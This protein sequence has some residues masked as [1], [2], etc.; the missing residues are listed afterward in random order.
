MIEIC[1][2]IALRGIQIEVKFNRMLMDVERN[3]TFHFIHFVCIFI[4]FS[5]KMASAAVNGRGKYIKSLI[6]YCL[7]DT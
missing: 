1:K 7:C 2:P 3:S 5:L 4:G 6:P